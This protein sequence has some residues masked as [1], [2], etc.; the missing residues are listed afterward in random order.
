MALLQ[1][2]EP[3]QSTAP[4]QHKLAVGIDLG[5]TNSL[6]AIMKDGQPYCVKGSD[7]KSALMPSILHFDRDGGLIVGDEA[8][9]K[10]IE[11]PAHTIYSVKR[12]MG[13]SYKDL[14]ALG[15]VLG[16]TVIDDEGDALVKVRVNDQFYTPIELSAE[17]LKALKKRIESEL[18]VEITKAVVTVP[19]YFNDNQ[20]QATRDAGKLAGLDI[21]R[22]VN[23]P[24]AAALAYGIGVMREGESTGHESEIIAVY[25]LGGGTFDISILQ[26]QD[27][28]FE[29]LAGDADAGVDTGTQ[30]S[31][32]PPGQC[33]R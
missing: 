10:L 14:D 33:N 12:L 28:V 31:D 29:V 11:D 8:R 32:F 20:R 5:T 9:L 3:G 19:A 1:I 26:I 21:L 15:G 7:G 2:S 30:Q 17:I 25:V 22:I 18:G 27:G 16:Y 13:K 24:T 4:H 6:V 23:E